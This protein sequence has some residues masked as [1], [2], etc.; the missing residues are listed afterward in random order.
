M[1][2]KPKPAHRFTAL[3]VKTE[4]DLR[5]VSIKLATLYT[6]KLGLKVSAYDAVNMALRNELA[7]LELETKS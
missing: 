7:R 3:S 6:T 1:P 2:K 4:H 5:A